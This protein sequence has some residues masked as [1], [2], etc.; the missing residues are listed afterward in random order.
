VHCPPPTQPP[1]PRVSLSPDL[2]L[3]DR[4][5]HCSI[6]SL[7]DFPSQLED[8]A[9]KYIGANCPELVTLNLQTCLVSTTL[10]SQ[11]MAVVHTAVHHRAF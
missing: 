9:L 11:H 3:E 6:A 5:K 4:L 1:H 10:C 8:E 7:S 2:P